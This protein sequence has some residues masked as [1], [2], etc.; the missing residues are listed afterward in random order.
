MKRGSQ[1]WSRPA[2][3]GLIA[4]QVV[5]EA[6]SPSAMR[7]TMDVECP[8]GPVIRLREDVSAEVL[9]RVMRACLQVQFENAS[10][11]GLVRSC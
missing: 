10:S 6:S 8:G 5:G 1:R 9:E 7:Q 11:S 4:V 2:G 3:P